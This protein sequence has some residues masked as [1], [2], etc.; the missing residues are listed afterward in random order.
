VLRLKKQ[1]V[2]YLRR[3]LWTLIITFALL[4]SGT[5]T[6]LAA[7]ST[8]TVQKGD[9]LYKIAKTHKVSV[10]TLKSWN[11][12]KSDTIKLNQSLKISS[13]AATAAKKKKTPSRTTE[14]KVVK[15]IVV[16]AS[17]FT[18]TCNGCSG[19]TSTG[20][21]LKRNPDVKVI[22]VDPKVIPLGTKVYVE[23]YGYAVAGDTGSAIKGNKID[24][25]FSSKSEAYK[26]GRKSVKVKILE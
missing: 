21:N 13:K 6:S 18:A 20:I 10:S 26:W 9:T 25:F 7:S 2:E 24:V 22:A 5:S 15:E 12:L 23:G 1:G 19:V 3:I 11:N 8:Y 4:V 14:D 16:S 17:A